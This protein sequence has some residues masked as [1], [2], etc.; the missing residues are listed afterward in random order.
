MQGSWSQNAPQRT[1]PSLESPAQHLPCSHALNACCQRRSSGYC[2]AGNSLQNL[3]QSSQNRLGEGDHPSEHSSMKTETLVHQAMQC[4]GTQEEGKASLSAPPR[5]SLPF[6]VSPPASQQLS[7]QP[8]V[9]ISPNWLAASCCGGPEV[10]LGECRSSNRL[11]SSCRESANSPS[12][13]RPLHCALHDSPHSAGTHP[14]Q[15]PAPEAA[16][17]GLLAKLVLSLAFQRPKVE[18]RPLSSS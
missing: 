7:L 10:R 17:P 11:N 2:F 4:S 12:S 5:H 14:S 8:G 1:G 9:L 15:H 18:L 3:L 16:T 6:S 13:N